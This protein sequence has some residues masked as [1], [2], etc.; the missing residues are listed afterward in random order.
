MFK[1]YLKIAFRNFFAH[2]SYLLINILGLGIAIAI[3]IIAYFH[4]AYDLEFDNEFKEVKDV[5]R[6]NTRAIVNGE[7]QQSA[8]ISFGMAKTIANDFPAIKKMVRYYGSGFEFKKIK[9]ENDKVF[10]KDIWMIYSDSIFFDLFP[11]E[12][13]YGSPEVFKEKSTI[14]LNQSQAKKFFGE[15]NPIGKII[16]LVYSNQEMDLVVRGIVKDMGMN[17]S[18]NFKM[19]TRIE[20]AFELEKLNENDWKH[21]RFVET[22][23]EINTSENASSISNQLGKYV[24]T[25]NDFRKDQPLE[26]AYLVPFNKI[27]SISNDV[28]NRFTYNKIGKVALTLFGTIGILILM[29]ACFNYTNT[30]IALAGVRL[31]EIGIRKVLGSQRKHLI[32][33]FLVEHLIVVLMGLVLGYVLS[34]IISP[35]YWSIWGDFKFDFRSISFFNLT[36]F[37][38]I[39]VV[40]TTIASGAYPAFYISKLQPANILKRDLQLKGENKFTVGL[41]LMQFSITVIGLGTS[42]IFTK[43]AWFIETVY[44][45][46]NMENIISIPMDGKSYSLLKSSIQSNPDIKSIGGTMQHIGWGAWNEKVKS[47]NKEI[48]ALRLPVGENYLETV[49]VRLIAGRYFSSRLADDTNRII[50]NEKFIQAVGLKDPLNNSVNIY[51]R[52]F[53]II[54]VVG[55]FMQHGIGGKIVPMAISYVNG[56]DYGLLCVNTDKDNILKV[57]KFIE[58]QWKVCFPNVAYTGY[59]QA[60]NV[61]EEKKFSNNLSKIFSFVGSISFALSLIGLFVLVSLIINK[62]AKEVGIRKVLGASILNIIFNLSKKFV[63]LLLVSIIVGSSIGYFVIKQMMDTLFAHHIAVTISMFL[64]TGLVILVVSALTICAKVY[65]SASANPVDSLRSE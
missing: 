42:I 18:I 19:I 41:L 20:N 27:A 64:L 21:W 39:L 17:N 60:N 26:S 12:F 14:V 25:H 13:V 51:G 30:S 49:G 16:T 38:V 1:N 31:K 10:D 58:E 59:P 37:I 48:D 23:Y 45:G 46:Y 53:Q 44:R 24:K 11:F 28:S 65:H 8:S 47:N 54:G 34:E 29:I 3:S 43:N 63:V 57:N 33:Q 9:L 36:I 35:F 5:Y 61:E 40:V 50:V 52:P 7:K 22:F 4:L 56:Q 6:V 32:I 62:R 2:K 15:V 55:D